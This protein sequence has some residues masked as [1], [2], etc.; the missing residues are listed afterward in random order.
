MNI[1]EA[2]AVANVLRGQE[3]A[4][5][6]TFLAER[7]G[8]ALQ[9]SAMAILAGLDHPVTIKGPGYCRAHGARRDECGCGSQREFGCACGGAFTSLDALRE[10]I[11][12]QQSEGH[13]R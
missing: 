4:R 12:N 10:H 3:D 5:D 9:L 7:A 2:N 6:R 13:A 11:T 1:S 8:R